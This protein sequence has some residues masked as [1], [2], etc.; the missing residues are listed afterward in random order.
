LARLP[1]AREAA[2]GLPLLLQELVGPPVGVVPAY[3]VDLLLE[4]I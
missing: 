2:L 3:R 1:L 4:G